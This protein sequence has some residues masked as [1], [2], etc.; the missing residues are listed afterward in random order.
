MKK[1]E[2]KSA[3]SK[4]AKAIRFK[5]EI[6]GPNDDDY[7]RLD[8]IEYKNGDKDKGW[9]NICQ[10][11]LMDTQIEYRSTFY[12]TLIDE[13]IRDYRG[14]DTDT[15]S[16]I[17]SYRIQNAEAMP[18]LPLVALEGGELNLSEQREKVLFVVFFTTHCGTCR[19]QLSNLR[20]LYRRYSTDE[21]VYIIFVMDDLRGN[22]KA[23]ELLDGNGIERANIA[24]YQPGTIRDLIPVEPVI[25][26]VGRNRRIVYRHAGY[27][28]GDE[29]LYE[30]EIAKL[31][32]SSST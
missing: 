30:E 31:I 7:L 11:L 5:S 26:V 29:I 12:R 13:I 21:N 15:D 23:K 9:G 24:L 20:D 10:S 28:Q 19:H 16:F 1:G 4:I 32:N 22:E 18:E 8:I 25:W 6:S 27:R 14:G 3:L 2:F 17:D